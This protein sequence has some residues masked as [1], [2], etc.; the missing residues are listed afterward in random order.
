MSMSVFLVL[1]IYNFEYGI[2][3]LKVKSNATSQNSNTD[4]SDFLMLILR[5]GQA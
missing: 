3:I 2:S 5:Q 4:A 1:G